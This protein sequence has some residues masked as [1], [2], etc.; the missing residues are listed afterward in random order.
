FSR[1]NDVPGRELI[2]GGLLLAALLATVQAE[3]FRL[4][5][6]RAYVGLQRR[7]RANRQAF[8]HDLVEVIDHLVK[9]CFLT[10]QPC[11]LSHTTDDLMDSLNLEIPAGSSRMIGPALS[12]EGI[13]LF[14]PGS[15]NF[16]ARQYST[17][18][19]LR[20]IR[21]EARRFP[22]STSHLVLI[23]WQ[24]LQS[25]QWLSESVSRSYR[26]RLSTPAEEMLRLWSISKDWIVFPLSCTSPSRPKHCSQ[27]II[28]Y[29]R[30]FLSRASSLIFFL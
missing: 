12:N 19:C 13:D 15:D 18:G 1:L 26:S 7:G 25:I 9:G 21:P 14:I 10:S 11:G 6:L 29:S 3:E 23:S 17:R 5:I 24:T 20:L 22:S 8:L 16:S 27:V 4:L 2:F 28:P 30:T